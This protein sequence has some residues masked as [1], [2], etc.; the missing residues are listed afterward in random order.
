MSAELAA[1]YYVVNKDEPHLE[2]MV[3][4]LIDSHSKCI[5][6]VH[7]A[8]AALLASLRSRLQKRGRRREPLI[9]VSTCIDL[10]IERALLAAGVPFTRVVQ[11]YAHPR[12][13]VS[14]FR[15]VTL[16]SDGR[17]QLSSGDG[18][19]SFRADDL[20]ALDDAIIN[21]QVRTHELGRDVSIQGNPLKDLALAGLTE[22]IVYKFLGSHDAQMSCTI[23][24]DQQFDFVWR[25]LRQER[26]P[27]QMNNILTNTPLLFL[28]C[29]ILDPDFRLAY[30]T[31]L[32]R[33]LE[34]NSYKRYAVQKPPQGGPQG[35]EDR[36]HARLW[37]SI[38]NEAVKRYKVEV[39]EADPAQFLTQLKNRVARAS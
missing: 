13:D 21:Q 24:A 7:Q 31:L 11:Y 27:E 2:E 12:I 9:V 35:F 5:P 8:L 39:V 15:D 26:V 34:T 19:S 32:R 18:I 14:E 29:R 10:L 33:P 37:Q 16:A 17:V 25:V 30:H 4:G 6:L 23:S 22:P 1:A 36:A 28:G 3:C 20:P 38:K